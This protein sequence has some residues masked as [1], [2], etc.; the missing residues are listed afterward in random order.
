MYCLATRLVSDLDSGRCG[1][2]LSTNLA[3]DLVELGLEKSEILVVDWYLS[4]GHCD[5][6]ECE[7]QRCE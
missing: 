2:E 3:V 6:N 4:V 1:Q 5:V 7:R